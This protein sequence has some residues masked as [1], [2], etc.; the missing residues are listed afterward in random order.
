MISA[1]GVCENRVLLFTCP[2]PPVTAPEDVLVGGESYR[3]SARVVT[4]GVLAAA[5]KGCGPSE[6][7][8]GEDV[9]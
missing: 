2:P 6:A 8:R 3:I 4:I 9:R 1:P 7:E 5:I